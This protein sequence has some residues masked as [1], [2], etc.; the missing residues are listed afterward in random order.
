M[1]LRALI[2]D[3]KSTVPDEIVQG[4]IDRIM[5]ADRLLA[6]VAI[7]GSTKNIAKAIVELGKG[8]SEYARGRY[9]HAID[10]YKNAW[11]IAT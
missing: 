6:V 10:H 7:A 5:E 4:F 11:D 3:T 1:Q 9:D 8:D 2:N